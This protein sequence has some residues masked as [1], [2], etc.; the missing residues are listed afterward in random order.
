M[1]V[2]VALGHEA[3]RRRLGDQAPGLQRRHLRIVEVVE[4]V[5]AQEQLDPVARAVLG[6]PL[7]QLLG[8][9]VLLVELLQVVGG[10]VD[11]ELVGRG[12]RRDEEAVGLGPGPADGE[13][14]QHLDLGQLAIDHELDV[15]A[16]ERQVLV[17]GDVLPEEAEVLRGEGLAVGP[18]VALA[19]AQGEDPAIL[20]LVAGEDVGHEVEV[21]VEAD[22][23]RVAV[24]VEEARLA[25]AADQHPQLAAGLAD[26]DAL[27]HPRLVRRAGRAGP[28]AMPRAARIT[29]QGAFVRTMV[30]FSLL[31]PLVGSAGWIA[32]PC[33]A[34]KRARPY[35][36][37]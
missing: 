11:E 37:G 32:W 19:Q 35:V 26:L 30:L 23:V 4:P 8:V 7:L 28:A 10:P 3:L 36:V 6:D 31:R 27:D 34:V 1:E 15:G 22:Q 20:D 33:G 21:A 9:G 13:L 16:A 14:V 17:G 2:G 29:S 18:F 5:L 25:L 24:D 12:D